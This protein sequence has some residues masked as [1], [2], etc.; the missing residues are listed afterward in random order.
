[1]AARL[2]VSPAPSEFPVQRR[3][4]PAFRIARR[5]LRSVGRALFAVEVRGLENLRPGSNHVIIA[6]HLQWV[7]AFVLMGALP[8][9]PRIH[10]F[11]DL[12]GTP[13]WAVRLVRA[14]GGVIP[15]DRRENGNTA[16]LDH[17]E[18]CSSSPRAAAT[19]PRARPA[20]SARASP[21][22]PSTPGPPSSPSASPAPA[23]CGCA[24]G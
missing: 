16:V 19:R 18:G 11:G 4:T 15:I 21:T 2:T 17:A 9:Q 7:D 1:M 5:L 13:L 12:V 22:S 24:S 3:A 23:S 6:N 8:A 14:V 10:V 20:T